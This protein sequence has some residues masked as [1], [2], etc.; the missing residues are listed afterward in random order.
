[1]CCDV[2]VAV[3][4]IHYKHSNTVNNP[5]LQ[6]SARILIFIVFCSPYQLIIG[7]TMISSCSVVPVVHDDIVTFEHYYFLIKKTIF[8]FKM[9]SNI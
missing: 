1:M 4:D 2:C 8:N 5:A 9:K 3:E 7:V 6:L